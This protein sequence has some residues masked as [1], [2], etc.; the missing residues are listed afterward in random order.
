MLI[1]MLSY[2]T[3]RENEQPGITEREAGAIPG[4][5]PGPTRGRM[6][7]AGYGLLLVLYVSLLAPGGG[8]PALIGYLVAFGAFY[9]ATDGVLAAL[10]A[11]AL[12]R[13]TQATGLA[14]L[15]TVTSLTRLGGSVLFG[16]IWTTIGFENAVK[17]SA[18]GLVLGI[19]VG[20]T[21]LRG[22][23]RAAEAAA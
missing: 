9:S 11:S 2:H 10:G 15:L 1:G 20:A 6:L 22:G 14:L 3:L 17:V 23:R 16:L 18:V 4:K 12:P 7:I 8:T 13:G 21:L 5:C 19:L